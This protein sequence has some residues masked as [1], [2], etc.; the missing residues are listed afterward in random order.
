MIRPALMGDVKPIHALL[1][2]FANKGLLLGRALST[3]YDQLRDFIVYEERGTIVGVCSLHIC[4]ENLAE[5]RSLAVREDHQ[6]RGIGRQ[7]VESCLDD[8][9]SLDIQQIFA[10]TYQQGF[11]RRLGF[12]PIDKQSLPQKIWGD[13]LHCPK[14]PDCDEEALIWR[15][16]Q[17]QAV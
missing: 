11:F 10:L 2:Q 7:M 16:G 12:V 4:W 9:K 14:F 1:Q 5:I 3:L 15:E 6:R 13:C 17:N 8:A